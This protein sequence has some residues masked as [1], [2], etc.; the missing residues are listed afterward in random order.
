MVE[1]RKSVNREH[2]VDQTLNVILGDEAAFKIT[3]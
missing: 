3:L 2:Q 1:D